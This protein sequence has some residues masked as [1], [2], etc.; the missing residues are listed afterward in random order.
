MFV[1]FQA[2]VEERAQARHRALRPYGED[3]PCFNVLLVLTL[4]CSILNTVAWAASDQPRI[5]ALGDSLTAGYGLSQ[6]ES[7]PAQLTRKLQAAKVTV[8]IVNA[9]VSGDTTSGALQR[10][11]WLMD[12]P[13]D[14]A[15]I[16]LGANDA[17]R[18]VD[19]ALTEQNLDRIV[20][21]LKALGIPIL[22][23]GMKAPRNL[24]PDYAL[25]F[26]RIFPDLAQK[27]S[28]H[29]YPF[30]L[31]GIAA[32]PAFNQADGMHPNAKGVAIIAERMV[33]FI[34]NALGKE[35]Q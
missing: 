19:P 2:R 27:H 28:V 4:L 17:L 16:E 3:R 33:P 20:T 22:L 12:G 8:N 14:L 9:G 5:L 35:P 1:P 21:K 18:A 11:D 32:K 15:I 13:Y 7:F 29:F 26:D 23:A 24:G 31:D 30:F 34:I 6:P 10:I 25:R